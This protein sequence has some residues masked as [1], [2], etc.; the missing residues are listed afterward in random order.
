[1]T[2]EIIDTIVAITKTQWRLLESVFPI[3]PG[4]TKNAPRSNTQ[5]ILSE[6]A[7]K[8]DKYKRYPISYIPV[9]IH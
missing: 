8:I 7:I 2:T 6:T 1:M 9:F 5:N 3:L 4:S